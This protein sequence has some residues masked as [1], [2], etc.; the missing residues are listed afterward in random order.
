MTFI[1]P[2]SPQSFSSFD[3]FLTVSYLVDVQSF[4]FRFHGNCDVADRD[5][6]LL[7]SDKRTLRIAFHRV[8]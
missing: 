1:E 7:R 2:S 5:P 8:L 4:G 3:T 6:R